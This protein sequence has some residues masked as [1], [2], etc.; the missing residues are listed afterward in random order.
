MRIFTNLLIVASIAQSLS[1]GATKPSQA[2]DDYALGWAVGQCLVLKCEVFR[3]YLLTQVPGPQKL[4]QIRVV[5]RLFGMS[6]VLETIGVPYADPN[7]HPSDDVAIA[8]SHAST[9]K[10]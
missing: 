9:A 1:G 3:G 10:D 2:E 7:I 8:W 4:V 5:D 6:S